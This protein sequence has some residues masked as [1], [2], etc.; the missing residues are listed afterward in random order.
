MIK[1]IL[2][3]VLAFLTIFLGVKQYKFDKQLEYWTAYQGY[4]HTDLY[5]E[6]IVPTKAKAELA[7]GKIDKSNYKEWMDNI[8]DDKKKANLD[9]FHFISLNPYMPY[10]DDYYKFV[11]ET[12][13][14]SVLGYIKDLFHKP[15]DVGGEMF[16]ENVK[17][18]VRLKNHWY[19]GSDGECFVTQR[20]PIS[21]HPFP[22]L[23][24]YLYQ[25]DCVNDKSRKEGVNGFDAVS[26][27]DNMEFL[28]K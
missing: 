9:W 21:G 8:E 7:I 27:S 17:R 2:I 19:G 13:I 12:K 25:L 22:F 15:Y 20:Q 5:W 6:T 14:D 26:S 24:R 28:N 1:K 23:H 11:D 3:V 10:T 18:T 16:D 4:S